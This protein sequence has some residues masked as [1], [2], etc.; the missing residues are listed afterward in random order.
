MELGQRLGK[1]RQSSASQHFFLTYIPQLILFL[2]I[3]IDVE[4]AVFGAEGKVY[5]FI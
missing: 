5:I 4:S 1:L 3:K 2:E